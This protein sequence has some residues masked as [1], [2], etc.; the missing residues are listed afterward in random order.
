MLKN[1]RIVDTFRKVFSLQVL[2]C[3][4]ILITGLSKLVTYNEKAR[5]EKKLYLK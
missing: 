3:T 5:N 2:E 4:P 1:T